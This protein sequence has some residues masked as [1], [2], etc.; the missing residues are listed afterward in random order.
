MSDN[1]AKNWTPPS[2]FLTSGKVRE[3][4]PLTNKAF[5]W[6]LGIITAGSVILLL[7]LS[8]IMAPEESMTPGYLMIGGFWLFL[9]VVGTIAQLSAQRQE[10][11]ATKMGWLRGSGGLWLGIDAMPMN[12]ARSLVSI[13]GMHGMWRDRCAES[14]LLSTA[15]HQGTVD[16]P[17][18]VRVEVM[19]L[20]GYLPRV[21]VASHAKNRL[22]AVGHVD[23]LDV[24]SAEFNKNFR[25]MSP[26]R[27]FA[28]AF[29]SPRVMERMLRE[30][31]RGLSLTVCG[32]RILVWSSPPDS[33]DDIEAR[34]NVMADV[35]DLIP[36]FAYDKR[37]SDGA[38]GSLPTQ[39]SSGEKNW[40]AITAIVLCLTLVA[41]LA[42]PFGHMALWAARRGKANNAGLAK[43]ALLFGYFVTAIYVTALFTMER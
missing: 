6:W 4:P 22:T 18:V 35:A 40:M 1:V 30:D 11:A 43:M 10:A 5:A 28:H 16:L 29:L 21:E 19:E 38:E 36:E 34:L 26:N 2:S 39:Q 14:S 7:V 33:L 15:K 17:L 13:G 25:V 37:R 20:P 3:K 23:E 42:I 8:D 24:E 27:E 32:N 31:A 9:A 41:P 12:S